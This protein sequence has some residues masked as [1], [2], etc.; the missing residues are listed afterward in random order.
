[1]KKKLMPFIKNNRKLSF[2]LCHESAISV[3]ELE[4][5]FMTF[6][7]FELKDNQWELINSTNLEFL[8][9]VEFDSIHNRIQRY[10]KNLKYYSCIHSNI[11]RKFCNLNKSKIELITCRKC[12]TF[13]IDPK[14]DNLEIKQVL[15]IMN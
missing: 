1:M 11:N 13:E 2:K 7:G 14:F 15:S 9:D 8:T 12:L 3:L 10:I 4:S 5:K 6:I